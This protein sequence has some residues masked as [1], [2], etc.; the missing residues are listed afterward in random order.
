LSSPA[1]DDLHWRGRIDPAMM[2]SPAG[3]QGGHMTNTFRSACWTLV[4]GGFLFLAALGKL[5][6]LVILL[7]L[8]LLLAFAIGCLGLRHNHLTSGVKKG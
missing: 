1:D 6:L 7:P 4:L 3:A 2:N 5:D 8:S